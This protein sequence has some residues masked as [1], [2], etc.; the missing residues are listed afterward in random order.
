MSDDFYT[1]H[2]FE[3]KEKG[4]KGRRIRVVAR[5][6]EDAQARP[7]YLYVIERHPANTDRVGSRGRIAGHTLTSQWVRVRD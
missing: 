1:G 5:A 2:A 3:T 7:I 4:S 6:G